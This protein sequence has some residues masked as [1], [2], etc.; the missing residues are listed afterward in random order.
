MP[1]A[2]STRAMTAN[3]PSRKP[4]SRGVASDAA[5][6]SLIGRTLATGTFG[7]SARTSPRTG[8]RQ[9]HRIAG[10]AHHDER[11]A[12]QIAAGGDVPL[13]VRDVELLLHQSGHAVVP[14]VGHDARRRRPTGS[15]CCRRAGVR[16]RRWPSRKYCRASVS[17]TT[18]TGCDSPVSV[19]SEP[20]AAHQARAHG[21]E[22]AVRHDLPV[23]LGVRTRASLRSL[24]CRARSRRLSSP[25]AARARRR[26]RPPRAARARASSGRGRTPRP[27]PACRT[28]RSAPKAASSARDRD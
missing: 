22:G 2:A 20:A 15:S 16:R 7:S 8:P 13:A 25:A 18:A 14:L 26:R 28:A 10:G 4:V 3:V 11:I 19:G 12:N 6:T 17:L 9:R 21:L 27:A 24:R 5:T 23:A 1:T